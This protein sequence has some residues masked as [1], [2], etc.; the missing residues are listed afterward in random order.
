MTAATGELHG[1]FID[2]EVEDA[3]ASDPDLAAKLEEVCPVD[4]FATNADGT[5]RIVDEN[6]DECVLCELCIEAAPPGTVRVVKLYDGTK[7][8]R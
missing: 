3:V 4:I 5:L 1:V 6:L 8:E 2:L 7:L